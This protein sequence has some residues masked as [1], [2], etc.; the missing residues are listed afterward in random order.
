MKIVSRYLAQEILSSVTLIMVALL[1]MF[2]FFDLIQE[3]GDI[4]RGSY[5]LGQVLIFVL[6]S[7]PGHVYEVVPVSVLVGSMYTLGQFARHSE[8]IVLRVSGVS[9]ASIAMALL[10]VGLIFTIF[11]F[12]V[13]E[14]VTPYSEKTAHRMR[15]QATDS[16]V[17][18]DFRSGLWV[19]DGNS[20]VNVEEV[21]PDAELLNIHIYE[22]D[23]EFRLR[24]INNAKSGKYE[25]EGWNLQDV[26]QTS[27]DQDK[28]HTTFFPE[29]NWQSLIRPELLN[30]LLVVPEKMAAW[31]LYSFISH[32]S[33]NKQKT[34]R[35]E[36][37]LWSKMAYP[38]ASLVMIV[39]ALPFGFLQQRSSGV[40]AK[41]F[42]GIMLGILYQILN[43]LFLHL[44]LLNDWQ[45]W[46]SAVAPTLIFF[47]AGIAMLAWVERR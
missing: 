39:L 10:Q 19:K 9:I 34:S 31:N 30:I 15:I 38:I 21:L 40:S 32:L 8:L 28:V 29:A 46:F 6:L 7:V 12:V 13:G 16:V 3:L 5:G 11:T 41:I 43:R 27:F 35:Y 18:Q 24:R 17:A 37:A 25:H 45:P 4:G 20:F 2:S 36:I 42:A 14:L 33:A 22:F 44:G 23:P 1:A 26:T 47:G